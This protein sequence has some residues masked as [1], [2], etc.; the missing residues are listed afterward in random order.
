MSGDPQQ[1]DDDPPQ[2]QRKE[3]RD[4]KAAPEICFP[5]FAPIELAGAKLESKNPGQNIRNV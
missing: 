2:Q 5:F 1:T 4:S 3:D